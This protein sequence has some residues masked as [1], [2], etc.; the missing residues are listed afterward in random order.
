MNNFGHGGA[1][2]EKEV[3]RMLEGL[4]GTY[5]ASIEDSW[6]SQEMSSEFA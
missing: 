6:I 1:E 3:L 4:D 5:S 2:N